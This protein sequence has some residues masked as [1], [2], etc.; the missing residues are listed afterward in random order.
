MWINKTA[1][2]AEW[3][4]DLLVDELNELAGKFDTEQFGFDD[5]FDDTD[6]DDKEKPYIDMERTRH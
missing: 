4:Y 1:E 3:N 5:V 6:D 2:L